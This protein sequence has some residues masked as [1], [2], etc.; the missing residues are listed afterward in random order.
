MNRKTV[1]LAYNAAVIVPLVAVSLVS[2]I[3][4]TPIIATVPGLIGTIILLIAC[5]LMV[6]TTL[7]RKMSDSTTK[8]VDAYDLHC[9]PEALT[10]GGG[11]LAYNIMQAREQG[12]KLGPGDAWFLC[13]YALASIDTGEASSA[14]KIAAAVLEDSQDQKKFADQAN[15]LVNL[16]PLVLRLRGAQ[17]ALS[18]LV[19][20][21]E[22]IEYD[23]SG[24]AQQLKGYIGF[25][26]PILQALVDGDQDTLLEKFTAVMHSEN[27]PLRIRVLDADAAASIY[28]QRGD[29][30]SELEA[31]HFVELYANKL[32]VAQTAAA[33]LEEIF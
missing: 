22:L 26:R 27:Q 21:E 1:I 11:K 3:M 29:E 30:S 10:T 8:L 12:D 25:E 5:L 14:E 4:G 17:D 28:R 19:K 13:Y 33:R 32:P 20:A 18:L 23:T 16:E 24:A 6:H 2:T 15:M 31:L 9:D 7:R